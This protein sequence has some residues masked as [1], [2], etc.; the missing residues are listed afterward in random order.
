MN[1]LI[2]KLNKM[3]RTFFNFG[4]LAALFI[5]A[6]LITSCAQA[7]VDVTTEIEE[8]NKAFMDIRKSGDAE[9]LS[10]FYTIDAKLFPANGELV[11]GREAIKAF[12][13]EDL[14]AASSEILFETIS[15]E[16]YGDMAI[17]EGLY[18]VLVGSQEVGKGKYIVTWKKEGGQ[19]KLHQD[20]WNSDLPLPQ[21]RASAGETVWVVWN[22][23]K[24]DKVSQ[25]EEFNFS[26]LEPA[27]AENFPLARSTVRSLK[28]VEPNKDGTYTYFYLMDPAISPDGYGMATFLTSKYGKEKSDEYMEMFQDCLVDGQEWVI[29]TQTKW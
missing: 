2:L 17:E 20:I 9:A 16:G 15:A 28:P 19:W 6:Y 25:F 11:V 1:L 27:I 24:A 5:A 22:K 7:P 13:S 10:M 14:A 29:T 4:F 23:I 21:A 12:I 26:Y 18:K 3:K 8:A